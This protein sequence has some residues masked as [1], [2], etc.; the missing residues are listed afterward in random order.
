MRPR[1]STRFRDSH[2][3]LTRRQFFAV[4]GGMLLSTGCAR[5]RAAVE[6]RSLEREMERVLA[7]TRGPGMA[8]AI[9]HPGRVPWSRGFGLADVERQRPMLPDTLLNVASVSKTVTATAVMQLWEQHR[10]NLRDAVAKY[11]PFPLRNPHFPE[12]PITFEQLLAHRSSIRDDW[13][14]LDRTYVC[15]DSPV[16]LGEWLKAYFT[17]EGTAPSS[18]YQWSPGTVTP[19]E[20]GGYSN[21][22]FGLLGYL[23]EVLS[24]QPFSA[25]CKE[26]IFTPLGMLDTGWFL[27][28]VDVARHATPYVRTSADPMTPNAAELFQVLT[29]AGIDLKS[30]PPGS[31]VPR[32]LYSSSSYPDGS[33]RTS[34]N[35]LARFLGA[36]LAQ[37]RA[38][39]CRLLKAETLGVMFSGSHFGRHLGW[40]AKTL[41]DGRSIILHGGLDPGIA[42]CIAFEPSSRL[43]VVCLR[44]YEVSKEEIYRSIA[45]L[46]DAGPRLGQ[47]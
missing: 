23:V 44:N 2:L 19:P 24:Q 22:G 33:L 20:P 13:P 15:G 43:G 16:A 32:C 42:T 41:S 11:L 18:W 39:G 3:N 8:C 6:S 46:L 30:L 28:E 35:D 34:A 45:V 27:R 9:V 17:P 38:N 1:H 37:G 21:V 4:T 14:R 10:F 5:R 25:F 31:L 47:L 36:Y 26:R 40:S 29:P 7:E 12:V